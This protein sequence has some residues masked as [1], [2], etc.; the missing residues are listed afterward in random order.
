MPFSDDAVAAADR[1]DC[2]HRR[3]CKREGRS[4]LAG[5]P[6]LRSVSSLEEASSV[7]LHVVQ[8]ALGGTLVNSLLPF[9]GLLHR[10]RSKRVKRKKS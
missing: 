5:P 2:A 9:Y 7:S 6:M 10:H 4:H 8:S 3:Q 1:Q